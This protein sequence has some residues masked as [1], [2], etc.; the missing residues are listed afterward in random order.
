[1]G[2]PNAFEFNVR[3]SLI[4]WAQQCFLQL[5]QW[6]EKFL[7]RAQGFAGYEEG[8]VLDNGNSTDLRRYASMRSLKTVP[9]SY[10]WRVRSQ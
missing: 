4:I 9:T 10:F 1:M 3:I 7:D 6:A 2:L 8:V 5:V